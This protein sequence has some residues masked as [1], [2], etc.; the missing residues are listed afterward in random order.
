MREGL[1]MMSL[2]TMSH[3]LAPAAAPASSTAPAHSQRVVWEWGDG[4][5]M[6]QMASMAGDRVSRSIGSAASA[7]AELCGDGE[8]L[9]AMSVMAVSR[10]ASFANQS[11]DCGFK[12][13][14][15]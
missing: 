2:V 7:V 6:I 3:N 8:R 11:G 4:A 13:N 14:N 1:A 15:E 10:E 12:F 5:T 9:K